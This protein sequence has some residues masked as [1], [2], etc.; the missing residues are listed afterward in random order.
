MFRN[1]SKNGLENY[2]KNGLELFRK[3]LK[4]GLENYSKIIFLPQLEQAILFFPL[5]FASYK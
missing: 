2:S 1:Y 3:C 4:N 5:D